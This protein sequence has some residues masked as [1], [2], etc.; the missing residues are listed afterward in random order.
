V[1]EKIEK[2]L[3]KRGERGSEKR[4]EKRNILKYS[5]SLPLEYP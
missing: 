4:E 5:T 1:I 2:E 3:E